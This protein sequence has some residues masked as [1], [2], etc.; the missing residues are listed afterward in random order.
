MKRDEGSS[1]NLLKRGMLEAII[2]NEG[3]S[4]NNNRRRGMFEDHEDEANEEEEMSS[5]ES[6]DEETGESDGEDVINLPIP[7]LTELRSFKF[8][9]PE[10]AFNLYYAAGLRNGFCVR[11]DK[12]GR[13]KSRDGVCHQYHSFVCRREGRHDHRRDIGPVIRCGCAAEMRI[14]LDQDSGLWYVAYLNND[15]NHSLVDVDK[16]NLIVEALEDVDAQNAIKYLKCMA[17]TDNVRYWRHR[18]DGNG[19][20]SHLFWSDGTC[21]IDYKTFG[22]VLAIEATYKMNKLNYR[23]V[24]FSGSN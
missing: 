19:V 23:L 13:I 2:P 8:A 21:Q 24:V 20:L 1:W 14:H 16:M 12:T 3:S 5:E 11:K 17:F 18:V 7:T 10:A 4:W 15:H 9:D 22:D 6:E